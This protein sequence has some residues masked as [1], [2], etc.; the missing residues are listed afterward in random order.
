M[1]RGISVRLRVDPMAVGRILA[2]SS[3]LDRLVREHTDRIAGTANT[4]SSEF[5]TGMY[6]DPVT[7]EA[8]GNTQPSYVGDVRRGRTGRPVGLVRTGNYSAM[9]DN[10]ENNT[11]LKALGR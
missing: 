5:R 2:D 4:L 8:R 6:R 7:R 10:T 3:Q 9:R 1:D 11:L